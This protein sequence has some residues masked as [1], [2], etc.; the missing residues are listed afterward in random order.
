MKIGVD[1]QDGGVGDD[2]QLILMSV[3]SLVEF[4]LE[5]DS[6]LVGYVIG[7]FDSERFCERGGGIGTD[8]RILG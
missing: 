4:D 3:L 6:F 2:E 1:V 5:R 8:W 7:E